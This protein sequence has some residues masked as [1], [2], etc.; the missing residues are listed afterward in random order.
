MNTRVLVV[1]LLIV[2]MAVYTT[3]AAV[4]PIEKTENDTTPKLALHSPVVVVVLI[5][6]GVVLNSRMLT[7]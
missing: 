4:H 3:V 6:E 2:L 1:V 5:L 7:A